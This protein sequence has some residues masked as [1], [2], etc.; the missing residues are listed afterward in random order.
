MPRKARVTNNPAII[1]PKKIIGKEARLGI[2]NKIAAKELVQT[3][4]K[5]SG[6]AAIIKIAARPYLSNLAA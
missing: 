1:V 5:G 6:V 4:A 3:P 2:L